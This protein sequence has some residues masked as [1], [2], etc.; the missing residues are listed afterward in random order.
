MSWTPPPPEVI[1]QTAE[2]VLARPEFRLG[3]TGGMDNQFM[4]QLLE[5]IGAILGPFLEWFGVL[6]SISPLLAWLI[7]GTL[8]VLLVLLVAHIAYSLAAA[9]RGPRRGRLRQGGTQAPRTAEEWEQR[10]A[11]LAREG[12]HTAAGRC[13]V[14]AG[15][16]RLA[17][18]RPRRPRPGAT[19]RE[20]LRLFRRTA[21]LEPLRRLVE[22]VEWR[23]YAGGLCTATDYEGC[24]RDYQAIRQWA[25]EMSGAQQP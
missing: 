1:R 25:E 11:E 8:F 23:W 3:E 22:T 9:A 18:T 16:L 6:A 4:L 17:L 24:L 5:W 14:Q 19:S 21:A 15:L 7:T 13:L 12:E 2:S 20:Y 10:A